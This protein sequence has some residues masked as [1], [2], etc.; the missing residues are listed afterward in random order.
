[1]F[2]IT[3]ITKSPETGEK[4][5]GRPFHASLLCSSHDHTDPETAGI[6]LTVGKEGCDINYPDVIRREQDGLG[7][8]GHRGG[9]VHIVART[10]SGEELR[11]DLDLGRD[12]RSLFDI[13][14]RVAKRCNHPCTSITPLCVHASPKFPWKRMDLSQVPFSGSVRELNLSTGCTLR[15]RLEAKLAV[16]PPPRP[17][18]LLRLVTSRKDLLERSWSSPKDRSP[19]R[20]MSPRNDDEWR[21][22]AAASDGI[23]LVL[24]DIN[25]R[26]CTRVIGGKQ[27]LA[28]DSVIRINI[29][30]FDRNLRFRRSDSV[31]HVRNFF[32]SQV[33][34]STGDY[35]SR[36]RFFHR[37][38]ELS[39]LRRSLESYGVKDGST[40]FVQLREGVLSDYERLKAKRNYEYCRRLEVM[41]TWRV[42][43]SNEVFH[44]ANESFVLTSQSLPGDEDICRAV[45]TDGVW[46]GRVASASAF[47]YEDLKKTVF[48]PAPA[49]CEDD[50]IFAIEV[51]RVLLNI[52]PSGICASTVSSIE[53][54]AP[55]VGVSLAD[56]AIGFNSTPYHPLLSRTHLLVPG[57]RDEPELRKASL[58]T[59]SAF[60][61]NVPV[62]TAGYVLKG[63]AGRTSFR[64]T[65]PFAA[66]FLPV[67][68]S[69][70]VA[71]STALRLEDDGIGPC[72]GRRDPLRGFF[73]IS[74]APTQTEGLVLA[75]GG[76]VYRTYVMSDR[77]FFDGAW[78]ENITNPD[79]PGV[80]VISDS[81]LKFESK[82]SFLLQRGFRLVESSEIISSVT[83]MKASVEDT[84]G[85]LIMANA[86]SV[87]A[88]FRLS[89]QSGHR[90][91]ETLPSDTLQRVLD[92]YLDGFDDLRSIFSLARCSKGLAKVVYEE[93]S[94]LWTHL[95]FTIFCKQFRKRM[96]DKQ[97]EAL[98]RKVD[99]ANV[100]KL[101][102]L[103]GCR[104]LSGN[105]LGPLIGS[106]TLQE[107]N[108]R[109]CNGDHSHRDVIP[110]AETMCQV[111]KSMPPFS[112][113][114]SDTSSCR[115]LLKLQ[116]DTY[117][118]SSTVFVS[119][120]RR[121]NTERLNALTTEF[122]SKLAE[123]TMCKDCNKPMGSEIIATKPEGI[124]STEW[125]S[126]QTISSLCFS[127]MDIVCGNNDGCRKVWRCGDCSTQYCSKCDEDLEKVCRSCAD[128]FCCRELHE[129]IT[130]NLH[131]CYICSDNLEDRIETTFCS[132]TETQIYYIYIYS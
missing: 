90:S 62:I 81:G 47:C 42:K 33:S 6:I 1:M 34:P 89:W 56:S 88:K 18:Q 9:R 129:C 12:V 100:V 68:G 39:D 51:V 15:F 3:T 13:M 118:F 116:L 48:A 11:F 125:T 79:T 36:Y 120:G 109:F 58:K 32:G 41:T 127:C 20:F 69:T 115:G 66:K 92:G 76:Y 37:G 30:G 83:G 55:S 117:R 111:I 2:R 99:A 74:L 5:R 40:I 112:P 122:G 105:G 29:E 113:S 97:L 65:L 107:L 23:I 8:I 72:N 27:P 53:V 84:S 35:W 82:H 4:K 103:E 31:W 57:E 49:S 98:L 17:Q 80:A 75:A 44:I 121:E 16:S 60:C 119:K 110:D 114:P 85:E 26:N 67:E 19:R 96:R 104:G 54:V 70:S 131:Q 95:D 93:S 38:A 124:E 71:Y 7:T 22:C 91:L 64:D 59:I 102:D 46:G 101:L 61:M 25:T 87:P 10:V 123:S 78:L 86:N 50:L 130:C 28:D 21:S 94:Y 132:G 106:T 43:S 77:T 73:F 108:L 63:L 128:R 24:E 45:A 52:C 14:T 126:S